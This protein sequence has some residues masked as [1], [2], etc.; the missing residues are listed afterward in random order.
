MIQLSGF[1]FLRNSKNSSLR[2]T[3]PIFTLILILCTLQ[4]YDEG[5]R[6]VIKILQFTIRYEQKI[7]FFIQNIHFATQFKVQCTLLAGPTA[8][9]ACP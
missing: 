4:S 7:K 1:S 5:Q 8:A 2:V 6:K 9:R 3:V